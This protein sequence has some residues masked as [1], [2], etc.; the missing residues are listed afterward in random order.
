LERKLKVAERERIDAINQWE[1]CN[2]K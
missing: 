1:G 2:E